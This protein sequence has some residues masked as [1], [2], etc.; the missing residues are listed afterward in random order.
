MTLRR[1]LLKA[2]WF[3][4]AGEGSQISRETVRFVE[5]IRHRRKKG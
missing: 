3:T 5:R 2:S 1:R 4:S